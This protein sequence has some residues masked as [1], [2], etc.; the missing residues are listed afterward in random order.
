MEFGDALAWL[1][2][3]QN[4]ERILVGVHTG[5]P[6]PARMRRLVDVL[7]HPEDAFP[8]IHVTGTNG[9]TSTARAIAQLLM[10]KG[11]S[12]G[13]YTSPHLESINERISAD[14]EPISDHD[15]AQVLSDIALLEEVG[16]GTGEGWTWFEIMT[17]AALR[18]FADRPVD[19]A[20][21]EVG[22]GGRWDAT[23]VVTAAVAVVTNVGLDHLELLGPTRSHV[24]REKAGIV[25]PGA[26]LVLAERDPEL[27][28]IF[29]AE[30][31]SP[32]LLAGRDWA[33]ESN[34]L[35]VG[36]RLVDIRTPAGR[37]PELYID[38][39][40][41][42][43]AE[44]FAA[45]VVATEAFFDAPVEPDLVAEAAATVASPGRLEVV[46]RRPLVV[47]DG[48][49]NVEGARAAAAAV[50]EEF[51]EV[52]SRI[53]VV[54]LLGGKD[55]AEMLEALGVRGAR[56]LV[57]CAPPS[58]RAQAAAELAAVAARFGVPTE[59]ADSV[60]E[61]MELALEAAAPE[62]LVLVS[63]TLYLVG[64]A[65]AAFGVGPA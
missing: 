6:D 30:G 23:N 14:G 10:A 51:A 52:S 43:Q 44:N 34:E 61:A 28:P 40:G 8:V 9:K 46:G 27:L 25:T 53:L 59:V 58:P 5:P 17:G 20:V 39:H 19:V 64:A 48:A 31:A 12:V 41:R 63:G 57:V 11:L 2:R 62:D 33:V 16:F 29:E 56:L 35:A 13:V 54:G 4:L 38:L 24:A 18:F 65:R 47:L 42:H 60:P 1:D 37:Y 15:L 21:I 22:I 32:L 55:P 26:P 45:A 7:G 3:H 49:K 36:G 50:A